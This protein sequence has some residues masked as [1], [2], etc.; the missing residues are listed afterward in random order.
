M[1]NELRQDL[2]DPLT[3]TKGTGL[4]SPGR[5]DTPPKK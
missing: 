1:A 5:E 4:R 2:G 3:G